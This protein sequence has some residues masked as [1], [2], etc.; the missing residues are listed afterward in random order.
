MRPQGIEKAKLKKRKTLEEDTEKYTVLTN[1]F[2]RGQ[3]PG[4]VDKEII[5]IKLCIFSM[6]N[7]VSTTFAIKQINMTKVI[8]L[9]E[10]N[11]WRII[12][13]NP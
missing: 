1:L 8:S 12:H 4:A 9:L 10:P 2:T 3:I 11:K 7:K 6:A 5:Q 13:D